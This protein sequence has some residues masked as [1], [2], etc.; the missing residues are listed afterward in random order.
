MWV[1]WPLLYELCIRKSL[2]SP[3]WEHKL[4]PDLHKFRNCVAY[5]LNGAISLVSWTFSLHW[6]WNRTVL[7]QRLERTPLGSWVLSL[8]TLPMG[9]CALQILESELFYFQ[10]GKLP[11]SVCYVLEMVSSQKPG[12]FWLTLL[13]FLLRDLPA[14]CSLMSNVWKKIISYIFPVLF[15]YLF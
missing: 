4:F 10:F 8:Y 7:C 13:V 1:L 2:H 6:H 11:I 12:Q 3:Q 9:Y 5:C 14:L 15:L